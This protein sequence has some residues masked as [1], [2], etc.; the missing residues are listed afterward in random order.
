MPLEARRN[1]VTQEIQVV[2]LVQRSQFK[3]KELHST[4]FFAPLSKYPFTGRQSV[5]MSILFDIGSQDLHIL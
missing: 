5:E 1:P 4:A 3:I 2:I